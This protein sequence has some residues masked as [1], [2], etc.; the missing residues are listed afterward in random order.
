[1]SNPCN[2]PANLPELLVIEPTTGFNI[3]LGERFVYVS[4]I[5]EIATE[6]E[7]FI[8]SLDLEGEREDETRFKA[9]YADLQR[10]KHLGE[11]A[12]EKLNEVRNKVFT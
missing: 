8:R 4:T 3:T 6:L 7:S 5:A 12:A 11:D 2:V 10:I 9:L 1:M